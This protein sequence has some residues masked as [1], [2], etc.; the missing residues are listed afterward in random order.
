MESKGTRC[1]CRCSFSLCVPDTFEG[2]HNNP[3]EECG[4]MYYSGVP[5]LPRGETGEE[6]CGLT[7]TSGK[8]FW[9]VVD[10]KLVPAVGGEKSPSAGCRPRV[11]KW[12]LV[13]QVETGG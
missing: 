1:G 7:G 5:C 11:Q 10:C 4:Y 13:Y 8:Y 2:V 12:L 9:L 6:G 3:R